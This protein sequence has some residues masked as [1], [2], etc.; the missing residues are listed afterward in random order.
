MRRSIAIR[1]VAYPVFF[2]LLLALA[3]AGYLLFFEGPEDFGDPLLNAAHAG[4]LE[5]V[6]AQLNLGKNPDHRDG[7]GHCPLTLA[8]YAGQTEVAKYLLEHGAKL[9][10]KDDS[11]ATPLYCA[12]YYGH[13]ET[14]DFLLQRGV[15]VNAANKYGDT[16]LMSAARHG[17][18]GMLE[19]LLNHKADLTK[20]DKY[21][22]QALHVV[23]RSTEPKRADR[24]A[25][26]KALL[27]HGADPRADNPGG[28]EHDSEHDSQGLPS[29][30]SN[31]PN[32]GNTPL[33]IATTNGFEDIVELLMASPA[34]PN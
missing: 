17:H 31:L 25:I 15:S 11:G 24:Y 20:R 33:E 26:A 34:K 19:L 1:V 6:T 23:L 14:A 16:P 12:A 10:V 29:F 21:G 13:V 2:I 7:F 5:A 8:A 27:A 9:D 32:K 18:V 30:F 4:D 3:A 22:W 28:W